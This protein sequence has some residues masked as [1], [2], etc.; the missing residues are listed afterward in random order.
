MAVVIN[1]RKPRVDKD[2]N[3]QRTKLKGYLPISFGYGIY[4]GDSFD[5]RSSVAKVYF[6]MLSADVNGN[7]VHPQQLLSTPTLVG[8][9]FDEFPFSKKFSTADDFLNTF[10]PGTDYWFTYTSDAVTSLIDGKSVTYE[11][12]NL[13]SASDLP[14]LP[15]L[16]ELL[17]SLKLAK[18]SQQT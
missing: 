5:E 3:V 18:I 14:G 1:V 13:I 12:L 9:S 2:G 11:S 17:G 16:N 6:L 4:L 7:V 15:G 10:K 8:I